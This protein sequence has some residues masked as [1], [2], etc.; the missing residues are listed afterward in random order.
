[1]CYV[2][3]NWGIQ[4][5]AR[6]KGESVRPGAE[7]AFLDPIIYIFHA[8]RDVKAEIKARYYG[9]LVRSARGCANKLGVWTVS[10]AD[11]ND[12]CCY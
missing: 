10:D 7:V 12:I 4:T 5:G 1:L 6:G 2:G 9:L 11:F 8:S 3:K